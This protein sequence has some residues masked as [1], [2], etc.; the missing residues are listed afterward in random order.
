MLEKIVLDPNEIRK[1][2]IEK[3]NAQSAGRRTTS[4]GSAA[5]P[6]PSPPESFLNTTTSGMD[7]D[8]SPTSKIDAEVERSIKVNVNYTKLLIE[9]MLKEL[10]EKV[11]AIPLNIRAFLKIYYKTL[12]TNFPQ[13]SREER[14]KNI[15]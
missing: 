5:S 11:H 15:V 14:R 12:K 1:I 13:I 10:Y 4:R 8:G 6:S 7:E 9:N 3:K 2:I